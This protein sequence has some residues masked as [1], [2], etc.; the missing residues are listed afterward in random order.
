MLE[1]ACDINRF[2]DALLL[3]LIEKFLGTRIEKYI[4]K[5]NLIK[6]AQKIINII[7][8]SSNLITRQFKS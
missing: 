1:I 2:D 8:N 5:Q 3:V 6:E 4:E 7:L